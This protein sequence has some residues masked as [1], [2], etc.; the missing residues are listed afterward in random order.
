MQRYFIEM[1][2]K[3]TNY[4]G[5]QIQPNGE[6]IQ[7][8]LE[9][10]FSTICR[11]KIAV[12]G[13]GRTDSGVHASYF[14]AHFDSVSTTLDDSSFLQHLNG[15]LDKDIVI[16]SINKVKENAHARF[17]AFS[18]TYRYYIH[19][20]KNPFKQ[21]T[22]WLLRS[23]LDIDKMNEVSR[24]LIGTHDFTSFSKLHTDVKTNDCT[25]NI[26][27]WE[28]KEDSIIFT[29]KANRFLRN[30]VRAIV[31]TIILAGQR[32]IDKEDLINILRLK[33]R[34][35]AGMSVPAQGLFLADIRY[36]DDVFKK[37]V[38]LRK[39]KRI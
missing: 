19:Q 37:S 3:G 25:V 5:W 17:D 39:G 31:G 10:A 35:S 8:S 21:E 11:E 34:S 36:P 22:S 1:A 32:K 29:V 28:R 27:K 26:A 4:H 23:Y 15:F 33:D 16:Y 14:V 24:L 13:A 18:R 9:K 7:S 30:M 12:T 20:N 38:S 6:T 2:Y